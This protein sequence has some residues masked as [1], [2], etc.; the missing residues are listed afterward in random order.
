MG[1]ADGPHHAKAVRTAIETAAVA[2]VDALAEADPPVPTGHPYADLVAE[3][4][5]SRRCLTEANALAL[6]A[7]VLGDGSEATLRERYL[8]AVVLPRQTRVRAC[9][10]D[11]VAK[12][13][14]DPDA[15]LDTAGTMLTGSWYACALAGRP[16]PPDWA[17]R[18]A[19]LVWRCLGGDPPRPVPGRDLRV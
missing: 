8:E 1:S 19:A 11:A 12:G 3:V 15:D 14:I 18:V 2:A 4:E 10:Q 7:V 13:L 9:L 5:H 6:A 17:H 16:P